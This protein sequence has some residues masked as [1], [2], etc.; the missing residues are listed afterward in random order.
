MVDQD[1]KV[2]RVIQVTQAQ[3][4]VTVYRDLSVIKEQMEELAQLVPLVSKVFKDLPEL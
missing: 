3:M 4:V 1:L 2:F